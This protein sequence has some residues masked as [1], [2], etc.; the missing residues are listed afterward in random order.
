[1]P[2]SH[3]GNVFSSNCNTKSLFKHCVHFR[4]GPKIFKKET[5]R[6]SDFSLVLSG[7][8]GDRW[9]IKETQ[10]GPTSTKRFPEGPQ[11]FR[12]SLQVPGKKLYF[13]STKD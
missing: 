6:G 7:G 11:L 2:L 9:T 8:K 10:R 12:N 1:M 3:I 13:A 4:R 5:K